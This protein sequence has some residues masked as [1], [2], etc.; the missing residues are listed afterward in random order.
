MLALSMRGRMQQ[1]E[2]ECQG[3][4]APHPNRPHRNLASIDEWRGGATIR[5]GL[6]VFLRSASSIATMNRDTFAR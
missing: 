2:Q 3:D 1:Q 6:S 5:T 4:D